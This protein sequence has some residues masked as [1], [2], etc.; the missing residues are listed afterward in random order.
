MILFEKIYLFCLHKPLPSKTCHFVS[1]LDRSCYLTSDSL[2]FSDFL[3]TRLM[4]KA[5]N[6]IGFTMKSGLK[7]QCH[8]DKL[9]LNY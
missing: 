3:H 1:S 9:P 5:A 7:H 6:K 8:Q 2:W 4:L